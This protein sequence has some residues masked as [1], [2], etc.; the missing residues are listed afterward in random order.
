MGSGAIHALVT[1]E[2]LIALS[3]PEQGPSGVLSLLLKHKS[4][5]WPAV[6]A[7]KTSPAVLGGTGMGNGTFQAQ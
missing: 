2:E 1:D 3:T 6:M 4:A 5:S 7:A